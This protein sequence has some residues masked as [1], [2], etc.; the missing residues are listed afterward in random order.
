[1]SHDVA[2]DDLPDPIDVA[3]AWEAKT[4]VMRGWLRDTKYAEPDMHD[5][6]VWPAEDIAAV[7]EEAYPEGLFGFDA[8][9]DRLLQEEPAVLDG[10]RGWT[11]PCDRDDSVGGAGS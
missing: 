9:H 11:W 6:S 2:G 3:E 5:R 10:Y 1:M 8:D 7:V 4:D